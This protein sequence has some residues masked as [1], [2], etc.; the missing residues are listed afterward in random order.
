M[1][2][3]EINPLG[4]PTTNYGWIKPTVGGDDDAWGGLLNTDADGIDSDCPRD[5]DQRPGSPSVDHA[6]A[7]DRTAAAGTAAT[8]A[9]ADHVHPV[10]T[11]RYAATNPTWLPDSA[12]AS[13]TTSLGPYALIASPTFTG[14]PAAPTPTPGTNTTQL[15]TT[16]FVSARF[17]RR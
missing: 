2:D 10:D 3:D 6:I 11:S 16:A 1:A 8:F 13:V 4:T 15:A 14:V 17:R 7:M 9:R 5:S 12:I